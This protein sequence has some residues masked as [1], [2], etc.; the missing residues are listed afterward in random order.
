VT[1]VS[2]GPSAGVLGD[3]GG[4]V[5]RD[6]Y[7]KYPDWARE[8]VTIGGY[9]RAGHDRERWK[10]VNWDDYRA[11][12]GVCGSAGPWSVMPVESKAGDVTSWVLEA[13][14]LPPSP[15]SWYT[16]LR[17]RDRGLIMSD[18]PAEIAGALPFL[19]AAEAIPAARVL[20]AGLGLGIV[21]ARLLR[22]GDVTRVDVAEIDAD[23]IQLVTG[24]AGEEG[25]PNEWA[26]DP[27]LHVWHEDALA[28]KVPFDGRCALHEGWCSP[29][30]SWEAAFFDIW[31][32]VSAGNLP[33]MKRLHR[34][35]ARR[36]AKGRMWSWERPECE[37]MLRR[38]QVVSRRCVTSGDSKR[39][40][41]IQFG[42][43]DES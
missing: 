34:R 27:R 4:V 33:S 17:H 6:L 30:P 7:E 25:A 11:R 23:V 10:S 1:G 22:F 14:Q 21:P 36:V 8:L 31:D 12:V 9:P 2:Y 24:G 3:G 18:I 39:T 26:A 32:L 42:A 38:G 13:E 35:Y 40:C 37:A 19:D 41:G 5:D 29:P 28:W 43:E 15:P 16:A 20:I